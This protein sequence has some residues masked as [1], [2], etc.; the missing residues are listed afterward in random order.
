[1]E[2]K[3]TYVGTNIDKNLLIGLHLFYNR[4]REGVMRVRLAVVT[5]RKGAAA[6]MGGWLLVNGG[7]V[8]EA[9]GI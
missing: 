5:R 7:G 3:G 2:E 4:P 8:G 1:L 6:V 9:V